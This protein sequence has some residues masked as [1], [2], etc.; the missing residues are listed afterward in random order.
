MI[1]K[2]ADAAGHFRGHPAWS[3]DGTLISFGEWMGVNGVDV[4]THIIWADG[5]RDRVLP[6]P[7]G[8]MWQSP[9]AWSNDGTRLLA[10]RGYTNGVDQA[11][12][13]VVPVDGSGP[14]VEIGSASGTGGV[15]DWA[16]AP[17]DSSILG[18]PTDASGNVLDQVIL[19]PV[20]R[21]TRTLPWAS[22][23]Q[24]SWQRLAP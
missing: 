15:S 12:P 8:A 5:T 11:R 2:G 9:F 10:I 24:P 23:S 13:V 14:G 16:W 22:V 7:T 18:T 20:T 4:H 6:E 1:L 17:D 3:P 19:D 21:T